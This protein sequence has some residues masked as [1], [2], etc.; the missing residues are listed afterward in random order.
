MMT[1]DGSKRKRGP[2]N[3]IA[4]DDWVV[5]TRC[6]GGLGAPTAP[7]TGRRSI[8]L[9]PA[10]ATLFALSSRAFLRAIAARSASRSRD[11]IL[12]FSASR[13]ELVHLTFCAP[14]RFRRRLSSAS[15]SWPALRRQ[16]RWSGYCADNPQ[17]TQH[18]QCSQRCVAKSNEQAA[19][20]SVAQA[21]SIVGCVYVPIVGDGL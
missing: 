5:L 7:G 6:L 3:S 12:A 19:T 2:G 20:E 18:D 8:V 14:R 11:G 4:A 10:V 17:P 9:K 15:S 16:Q 21:S 13:S 1:M